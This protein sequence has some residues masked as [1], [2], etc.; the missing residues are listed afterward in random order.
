MGG[1]ESAPLGSLHSVQ[2]YK[3]YA[4]TIKGEGVHIGVLR[5]KG[6]DSNSMRL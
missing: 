1:I 6:K 5:G 3:W 2:E 4:V